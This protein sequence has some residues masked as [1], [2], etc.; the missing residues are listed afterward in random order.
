M[1][2]SVYIQIGKQVLLKIILLRHIGWSFVSQMYGEVCW[3]RRCQLP[4]LCSR[5]Q[6]LLVAD[7]LARGQQGDSSK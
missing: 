2:L 6:R 1:R 3:L 4:V 7:N 5:E